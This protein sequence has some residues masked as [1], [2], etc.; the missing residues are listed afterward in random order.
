MIDSRYDVTEEEQ[1]K[2][3]AKFIPDGVLLTFPPKEKQRLI[4]MR[5]ISSSFL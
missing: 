4:V 1:A 2:T 3:I 5:K